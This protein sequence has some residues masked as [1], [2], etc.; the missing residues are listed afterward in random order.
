[1]PADPMQSTSGSRTERRVRDEYAVAGG[2]YGLAALFDELEGQGVTTREIMADTGIPP[3][4]RHRTDRA[5]SHAQRLALFGNARRLARG[6]DTGLRAGQRQKISDFG[7]YGYAMATSP[8]F[9][10]AFRF[11]RDHV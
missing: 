8:T 10:D 1:V 2:S 6:A 11:G 9:G 7:V 4:W 5:L 3:S